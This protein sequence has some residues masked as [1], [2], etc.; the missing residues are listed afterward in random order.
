MG[1]R[2][3]DGRR[4]AAGGPIDASAWGDVCDLEQ[5]LPGA[6]RR[7]ACLLC[8]SDIPLVPM[9]PKMLLLQV[10]R[11]VTV[12]SERPIALPEK[13]IQSYPSGPGMGRSG[14]TAFLTTTPQSTVDKLVRI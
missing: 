9:Q 12:V 14:G 4:W 8:L 6:E 13:F 1:R 7:I 3:P 11:P 5:G 2:R 10:L